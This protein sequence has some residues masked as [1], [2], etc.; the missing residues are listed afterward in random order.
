MN[1][2]IVDLGS[3]MNAIGGQARVAAS[4]FKGLG[5]RFSTHYLGYGTMYLHG[6]K[7]TIMLK[8][9]QVLGLGLKKSRISE[10]AIMRLGYNMLVSRNLLGLGISKGEL[11]ERMRR[12]KP[13]VIIANSVSDLP[14]LLFLR[15]HGIS[16]K[17]IYIDHGSISGTVSGYFSKEGIPLVFGAG[18]TALTTRGALRKFFGF[19]DTVIALSRKQFT[20]IAR[21]TKKVTYIPNGIEKPSRKDAA[22]EQRITDRFGIG[23]HE[24]VVLYIGRLFERQKSVSTLIKA[25]GSLKHSNMRLLIVGDGPSRSDYEA[26]ADGDSR[27]VFAGM[28]EDHLVPYVYDIS[29]LYVLPSNWEGFSLTLLEA[30]A[31]SLP[32]IISKD[33][34]CDEYHVGKGLVTFNTGDQE[35]LAQKI[36]L[37]YSNADARRKM[38]EASDA[39]AK[40]YSEKRMLDA[41]SRLLTKVSKE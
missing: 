26:I 14:L 2:L 3:K 6:G 21:F 18:V 9:G 28:I 12:I 25:F 39:L 32:I 15:S 10:S 29:Y 38:A 1:V 8:R 5:R 34:D 13:D 23:A 36:E 37:A 31:H 41:Y 30:A 17:S 27:V 11:L 22:L 40:R 7:G 16:F 24:F 35:D 4:L 20:D 19:F 33:V